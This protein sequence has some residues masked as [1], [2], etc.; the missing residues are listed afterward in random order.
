MTNTTQYIGRF[1]P[2]PSGP[3]HM[4]SLVCALASYLDARSN[5]GLWLVRM[6]DID[7]PREQTGAAELILTCLQQHGLQ[8]DDT[9]VMFQSRR[10]SAYNHALE[11]LRTQLLIYPCS[12]TRKRLTPLNGCYDGYCKTHPASSPAALR[13]DL[14]QAKLKGGMLHQRFTDGLQGEQYEDLALQ[15]DFVVHRKDGLFAYQLAVVVDDIAQG[16]SH[17]V[18]GNDL[19][20]TTARQRILFQLLDYKAPSYSHIPVLIDN[21]GNKLSK[22]NHAPAVDLAKPT[23]NLL[24]ALS[25]L[26]F[27]TTALSA[28]GTTQATLDWAIPQWPKVMQSL[29]GKPS[30]RD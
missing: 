6:E 10:A 22:Q 15:G 8:W 28:N 1:A 11:S 29:R 4:G 25:L 16:I 3:L 26:G 20:N 21:N 13:L 12:C 30:L 7:P 18:R 14:D 5:H 9:E 23:Q 17:V 2:S 19:L 24:H 27:D